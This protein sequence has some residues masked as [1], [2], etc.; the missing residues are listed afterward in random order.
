MLFLTLPN[1]GKDSVTTAVDAVC[2]YRI[3][4][5]VKSVNSVKN[6][7]RSTQLLAQTTLRNHLGLRTLS[8]ILSERD[9]ISH[10]IQQSL[11]EATEPWGVKVRLIESW[12]GFCNVG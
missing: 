8:E 7:Y 12:E 3:C 4:D 6:A 1:H 9:E 11:D 2:Y 10:Q 5:P